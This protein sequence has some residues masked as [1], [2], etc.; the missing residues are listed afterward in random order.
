MKKDFAECGN[1]IRKGKELKE[2]VN[3]DNYRDFFEIID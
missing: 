3:R 1:N 2:I